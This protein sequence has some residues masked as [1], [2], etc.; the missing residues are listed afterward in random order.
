MRWSIDILHERFANGQ[1]LHIIKVV[2]DVT[3][4]CL[5]ATPATSISGRRVACELTALIAHRGKP[6]MI[7]SDNGMA[8]TSRA[9]LAWMR[10][11][12]VNWHFIAPGKPMQNAFCESLNG[13]IRAELL[14]KSLFLG[15]DHVR[16][17]INRWVFDYNRRSGEMRVE[18]G[19]TL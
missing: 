12:G 19:A 17:K 18:F 4:E 15:L 2:D 10:A 14:N 9:V 1:P 13:Y 3:R 6:E 16:A 7:V 8:F 11:N 5:A